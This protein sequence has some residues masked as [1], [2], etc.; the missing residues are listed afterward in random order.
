MRGMGG[1]WLPQRARPAGWHE[2]RVKLMKNPLESFKPYN[3]ALVIHGISFDGLRRVAHLAKA[4]MWAVSS[5][6][7]KS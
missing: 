2:S 5:R 7:R 1:S 3:T 4:G 6:S